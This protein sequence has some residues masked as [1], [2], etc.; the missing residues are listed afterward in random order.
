VTVAFADGHVDFHHDEI[1]AAVW[2]AMATIDGG[3][4]VPDE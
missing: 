3:D 4:R 1:E 2:Q